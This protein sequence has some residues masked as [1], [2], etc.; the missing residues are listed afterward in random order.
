[1]ITHNIYGLIEGFK[2][3]PGCELT[4]HLGTFNDIFNLHVMW[5]ERDLNPPLVAISCKVLPRVLTCL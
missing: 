2:F 4:V 3:Y 5:S 1:M